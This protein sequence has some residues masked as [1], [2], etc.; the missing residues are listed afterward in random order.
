MS[1]VLGDLTSLGD[2]LDA[3]AALAEMSDDEINKLFVEAV[4]ASGDVVPEKLDT[5]GSITISDNF[6]VIK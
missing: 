2:S 6:E 4:E 5:T 3:V 1:K